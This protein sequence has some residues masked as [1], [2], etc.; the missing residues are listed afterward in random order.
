M[1]IEKWK[2]TAFGSDYGADFQ[3]FLEEITSDKLTLKEVFK[4]CDLEKYLNNPELLKERTDNNVQLT[5]SNFEQFVHY[6]DAVIALCAIVAESEA[7]GSADLT[8]AYGNKV[9]IFDITKEEIMPL[10]NALNYIHDNL[11]Q[12]VLFEMLGEE[13]QA[14][15]LADI[16]E[17]I[18]QLQISSE[19]KQEL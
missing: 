1:F 9:L 14:E 5:N 8:L 16:R 17:I 7:N 2:D 4:N 10:K 11:D 13:E 12:F 19:R 18:E 15:T 6:E 3:S